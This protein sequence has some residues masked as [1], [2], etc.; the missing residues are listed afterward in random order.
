MEA[1]LTISLATGG[2][3]TLADL[4]LVLQV[5]VP[6]LLLALRVLQVE[7]DDGLG[8]VDGILAV[9][10]VRLESLVDHVEGGGGR[11]GICESVSVTRCD[12]M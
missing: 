1:Q 6:A 12:D 3:G 9:G 4:A 5:E 7:S 8:L 10:V 11:E 2:S